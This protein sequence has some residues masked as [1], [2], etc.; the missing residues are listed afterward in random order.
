MLQYHQNQ[1]K[2]KS[3]PSLRGNIITSAAGQDR[4]QLGQEGPKACPHFKGKVLGPK[5]DLINISNNTIP[6]DVTY[7]YLKELAKLL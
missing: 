1:T 5:L 4:E 6:S 3:P 2:Q 7:V